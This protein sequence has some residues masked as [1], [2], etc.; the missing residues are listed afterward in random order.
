MIYKILSLVIALFLTSSLIA[1]N[2]TVCG[3]NE[4]EKMI[5]LDENMQKLGHPVGN[6]KASGSCS[7]VLISEDLFLSA[8]HCKTSCSSMK[9]TFGY[10]SRQKETFACKEII[11]A[12]SGGSNLDYLIIRLEGSPGK[13]WG[14]FDMSDKPLTKGQKLLMIHHPS[15]SP[16]KVSRKNCA[17]QKES[18]GFLQHNCDTEPGSSGGAVLLPD[19]EHPEKTKVVAVHTLGGCNSSST[20][21]NSGP[22]IANL[23]K[24]SQLI[25]SMLLDEDLE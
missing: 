19:D 1:E 9:V 4:M 3:S 15:G 25:R 17:F 20:S 14:W 5:A 21:F 22:S 12:G 11:E 7:G 24:K 6:L 18:N 16:M 10:L 23:A 13:T 2:R 8:A